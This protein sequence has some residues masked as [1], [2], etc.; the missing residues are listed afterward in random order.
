ME[1][2]RTCISLQDTR[3]YTR[4][5]VHT[6]T[7]THP[8]TRA[9]EG[10]TVRVVCGARCASRSVVAPYIVEAAFAPSDL[11]NRVLRVEPDRIAACMALARL[12]TAIRTTVAQRVR[13][14]ERLVVVVGSHGRA[15]RQRGD[16]NC[17]TTACVPDL[18]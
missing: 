11:G 14:A 15:E 1:R 16:S 9:E 7:R 3:T 10:A 2:R 12:R 8:I 5:H 17:A 18:I 13:L 6:Y 4:T